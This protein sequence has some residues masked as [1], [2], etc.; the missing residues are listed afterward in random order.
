MLKMQLVELSEGKNGMNRDEIL[1][2][3]GLIING[4]RAKDYGDAKEN[5]QNIADMWS[6]FLGQPITRQQVAV[7]MILVKTAR[8]IHSDKE[9]SWLDICG[10]AA[11]GGEKNV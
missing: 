2:K 7:C 1:E 4:E 6:V 10:Y 9:D 11:L 8:L 5:F 3:A